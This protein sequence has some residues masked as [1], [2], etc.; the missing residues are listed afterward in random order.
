MK[1]FTYKI[2]WSLKDQLGKVNFKIVTD[3]LEGIN[4][5]LKI[6]ANVEGFDKCCV[7]YLNEF[8][9]SKIGLVQTLEEFTGVV[10]SSDNA[11]N[12]KEVNNE[13]V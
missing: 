13:E 1:L 6:V 4:D 9:V 8:D 12:N 3:T 11:V 10:V 5:T 2:M 7:E